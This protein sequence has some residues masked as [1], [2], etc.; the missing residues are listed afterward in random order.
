[1]ISITY[2]GFLSAILIQLI[3]ISGGLKEYINGNYFKSEKK[4]VKNKI[5]DKI[6]KNFETISSTYLINPSPEFYSLSG[7][8]VNSNLSSELISSARY[9]REKFI[10]LLESSNK[11]RF[12]K[13]KLPCNL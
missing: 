6:E 3:D 13:F 4:V 8:L 7:Y 10:K 9:N 12:N 1:M 2:K 5:W 11:P